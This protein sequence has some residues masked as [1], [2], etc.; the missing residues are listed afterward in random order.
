MMTQLLDDLRA[1]HRLDTRWDWL[2][3][4]T[5]RAIFRACAIIARAI[6]TEEGR[7]T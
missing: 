6:A 7:V 3:D 4:R 1:R 2:D 5:A